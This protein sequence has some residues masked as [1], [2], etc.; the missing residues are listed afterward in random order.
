[1]SPNAAKFPFRV[2]FCTL[3]GGW[4]ERES[5]LAAETA[6]KPTSQFSCRSNVGGL[7]TPPYDNGLAMECLLDV[8]YC[9][10]IKC[11]CN[12][13]PR[14]LESIPLSYEARRIYNTIAFSFLA[15]QWMGRYCSLRKTRN[16][17]HA[18]D[19]VDTKQFLNYLL[20][21]MQIISYHRLI[22]IM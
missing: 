18:N 19:L 13:P 20:Y 15:I 22:Y 14:R 1:M 11:T 8:T 16:I 7:P 5:Y 3:P 12:S 21:M 4:R 9:L 17:Y 2:S 10:R 6:E